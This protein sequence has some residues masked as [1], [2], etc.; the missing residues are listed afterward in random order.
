[1]HLP[2][3]AFLSMKAMFPFLMPNKDPVPTRVLDLGHSYFLL[4]S[5]EL[6]RMEKVVLRAFKKFAEKKGWQIHIAD[7]EPIS[8]NHFACLR[9][10]NQQ[11]ARSFWQ[12]EKRED[13]EVRRAWNVKVSQIFYNCHF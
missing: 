13:E 7:D 8:F 5:W 4:G 10:P 6:V 1:M 9:L 12:E 11:E 3:A 2:P